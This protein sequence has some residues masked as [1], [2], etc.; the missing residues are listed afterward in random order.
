MPRLPGLPAGLTSRAVLI[1]TT[2]YRDPGFTK[3]PAVARSLARMERI[4]ADD[5]LGGWSEDELT[6]IQDPARIQELAPRLRQLTETTDGVLLLYYAG[7]GLLRPDSQLCLTL[8]E[9][10]P[11]DADISSLT[12]EKVR[13]Y[14]LGSPALVRIVILDCCHAGRAVRSRAGLGGEGGGFADVDL[15]IEG[16]YILAAAEGTADV[17]RLEEQHNTAT[18]FTHHLAGLVEEGVLGGPELLSLGF[19]FPRLRSRLAGQG[20]PRPTQISTKS[21]YRYPFTK[22]AAWETATRTLAEYRSAMAK[23]LARSEGHGL[24][25]QGLADALA[26]SADSARGYLG[27]DWIAPGDLLQEYLAVLDSHG[28]APD[29]WSR[30]RL[31]ELRD[32]AESAT[33]NNPREVP[34][35]LELNRA[36][37]REIRDLRNALA[38][39]RAHSAEAVSTR[40][41]ADRVREAAE[42]ARAAAEEEAERRSRLADEELDRLRRQVED[43]RR[44]L[45]HASGYTRQLE[46]ELAGI[47]RDAE[48]IERELRVL[49]RQVSTM[50]HEPPPRR[51][52]A[53]TAS[54]EPVPVGVPVGG[55]PAAEA[56]PAA[57]AQPAW[58]FPPLSPPE[59]VYRLPEPPRRTVTVPRPSW[60]TRIGRRLPG[61]SRSKWDRGF[62]TDRSSD[63]SLPVQVVIV[64]LGLAVV[65]GGIFWG[66]LLRAEAT[67]DL[68]AKPCVTAP[69]GAADC[70]ATETGRV[71]HKDRSSSGDTTSWTVTV[72]VGTADGVQY[73]VDEPLYASVETGATVDLKV[74]KGT[75]VRIEHDGHSHRFW[76]ADLGKQALD[77]LVITLGIVITV[78]L[79]KRAEVGETVF[80]AVWF[81]FWE[82]PVALLL[83]NSTSWWEL[84][85]LL[86]ALPG[87]IG[88]ALL[89]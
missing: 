75:V 79:W 18:S 14:L 78:A 13:E 45:V 35:L 53:A 67:G 42:L 26:L 76:Q 11:A 88:L 85:A 1:G 51:T 62:W 83:L 56:A 81:T 31:A 27:G 60:R 3:L 72:A 36:Q 30:D 44:Q 34:G 86:W 47:R 28:C 59:P 58:G 46:S 40:E 39:E 69:V 70:I 38:R 33:A 57:Q 80:M 5:R 9:T 7:H 32:L 23:T 17:V 52:A 73:N 4:L 82:G 74:W 16:T 8:T 37:A 54:A 6:V 21:S 43:Q 89:G 29:L 61:R 63:W 22:N 24:G 50:M 87:F 41:E 12:Y 66:V 25:L 64:L 68:R 49:R 20:L 48:S 71:T 84:L 19:L 77:V 55:G 15:D 65:G 10:D 2:T